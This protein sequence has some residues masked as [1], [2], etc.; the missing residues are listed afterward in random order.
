MCWSNHNI[1][2]ECPSD[3]L[4]YLKYTMSSMHIRCPVT[5][6]LLV[7][8]LDILISES[9]VNSSV[10]NLVLLDDFWLVL[11]SKSDL[12][13]ME[14]DKEIFLFVAIPYLVK[15]FD[16][17]DT[18]LRWGENGV[19]YYWSFDPTGAERIS[20]EDAEMLDLP[21]YDAIL[22]SLFQPADLTYDVIDTYQ[23][24]K[25]YDPN[26]RDYAVA[27]GWP[28]LDVVDWNTSSSLNSS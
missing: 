24:C 26:T 14:H 3:L 19:V 16:L 11:C 27:H 7:R 8:I 15:S 22:H 20:R 2:P 21:I 12:F 23:R 17:Q 5:L 25:G 28:L 6:N 4:G 13:E 10:I 1:H 18:F 9:L